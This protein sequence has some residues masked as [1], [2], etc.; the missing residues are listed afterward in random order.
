[1]FV[2]AYLGRTP[3]SWR[4]ALRAH[5]AWLGLHAT[6]TSLLLP[7]GALLEIGWIRAASAE[8]AP[9]MRE[10]EEWVVSS[11]FGDVPPA[12]LGARSRT[13]FENAAAVRPDN[14]VTIALHRASGDLVAVVPPASPQQLLYAP[15]AGGWVVAADRR[16]FPPRTPTHQDDPGV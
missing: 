8:R 10:S 16:Q 13:D 1:M 14:G 4:D 2:S 7:S 12:L 3:E 9:V 11:A 15:A 6:G 5:A